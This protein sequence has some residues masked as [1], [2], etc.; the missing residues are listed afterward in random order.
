MQ[1][2]SC[3]QDI[4]S[5]EVGENRGNKKVH[6]V[7]ECKSVFSECFY[8]RTLSSVLFRNSNYKNGLKWSYYDLAVLAEPEEMPQHLLEQNF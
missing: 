3:L 2:G 5:M 6:E 1:H 7:I 4:G 8:Y